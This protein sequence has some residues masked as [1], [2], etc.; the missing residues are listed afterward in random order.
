MNNWRIRLKD[1][2][3]NTD[4]WL[5]STLESCFIYNR[6]STFKWPSLHWVSSV[7]VLF[8]DFHL[9]STSVW[10]PGP[11]TSWSTIPPR[12]P[13]LE[14]QLQRD[15]ILVMYISQM[16]EEV[17]VYGT[18][19]LLTWGDL[20]KIQHNEEFQIRIKSKYLHEMKKEIWYLA[21]YSLMTSSSDWFCYIF[22]REIGKIA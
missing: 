17:P 11:I 14:N 5:G 9:C 12:S 22:S 4:F 15:T 16:S 18:Q 10:R 20:L 1:Y 7:H 3:S 8:V 6:M 2:A 13:S 21:V 19:S